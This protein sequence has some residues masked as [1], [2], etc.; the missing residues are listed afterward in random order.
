M[1]LSK[2]NQQTCGRKE[3]SASSFYKVLVILATHSLLLQ[4]DETTYAPCDLGFGS[5]CI[6]QDEECMQ[7]LCIFVSICLELEGYFAQAN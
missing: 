5:K 3:Q 6:A 4:E 7:P 1:D 2:D